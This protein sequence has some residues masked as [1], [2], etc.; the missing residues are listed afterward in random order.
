MGTFHTFAV[1]KQEEGGNGQDK[2]GLSLLTNAGVVYPLP[3]AP[4]E[5]AGASVAAEHPVVLP[6]A[7][8]AADL[9]KDRDGEGAAFMKRVKDT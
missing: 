3:D 8:V 4:L 5:E 2:Q 9:A 6:V 7:L 1:T